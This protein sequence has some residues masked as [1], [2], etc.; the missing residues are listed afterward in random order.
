MG[1]AILLG[2]F[3]IA[4]AFGASGRA[5]GLDALPVA[6]FSVFVFAGASQFMAVTLLSQGA[7]TL[8]IILA[9]FVLNSRHI[10]M[11][12]SLRDRITG[13]RIPRAL[14]AFGVTDEVFA[15]AATQGGEIGETELLI[16]EGLAYSGWVGGTIVGFL[17]GT[18]L[19]PVVEQAMGV[20]LYAMFVALIV[21][22]VTRFPR[23]LLPAFAAGGANWALQAAGVSVG[24][25]LVISI[26]A[27]AAA[28]ALVPGW[29]EE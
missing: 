22:A 3:S 4:I 14:L 21:P 9:T 5:I 1:F 8:S 13:S 2:Y 20:S 16:M 10:V 7:G 6:G 11:S 28:F 15:G 23:Y 18:I 29:S 12:I 27:V 24:I 25:S 26:A 19:P 17:V